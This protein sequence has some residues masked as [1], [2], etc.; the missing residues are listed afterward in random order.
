MMRTL[1]ELWEELEGPTNDDLRYIIRYVEPLRKEA[2]QKLLGQGPT[3]DDLRYIIRY[4]E[5]LR[6][7]AWQKLLGQGPTNDDLRY[8]I[9]YVEPLRK[10]AQKLLKRTHE[11]ILREMYE[12][13]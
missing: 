2:G 6:K 1:K 12:K 13:S 4:V 7:E 10:E 9:E 11:E 5:P 3:N 8:I